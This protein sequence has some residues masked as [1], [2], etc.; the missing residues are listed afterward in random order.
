MSLYQK[1]RP[2]TLYRVKGNADVLSTLEGMLSDIENC[3]HA[4]LLHGPTGCGKTTL[5]RIIA[6]RL[7]CKGSDLKEI[8]SAQF[9]GIDTAR[10]IR[11]HSQYKAIEGERRVWIIDECH[12]MTNDAQ[13]GLLKILEDTPNHVYFVLCTTDPQKLLP[14]IRS[15]CSMFQV[16][17][18]SDEDM[19][20]LLQRIVR[21]ERQEISDE[22][23]D[24]LIRTGQGLPRT[25]IQALEQVLKANPEKREEIAKQAAFEQSQSIDLCRALMK[26]A[27]WKEIGTILNGLKDQEAEGIRR[28]V[29]GYCQAV[30][31]KGD[32]IL[33]GRIMEEFINPFYD[34]G[35]P[36][37]VFACYSITKDK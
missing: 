24:I 34:S 13:N 15:R 10:D 17:P 30:L 18:L 7:G 27:S 33:A 31:L 8:D 21:K 22:V 11:S 14:T 16:K 2:P 19:R 28:V 29:L 32:V 9:R 36:Q 5:A 1:Y 23:Y 26:R 20:S 25:T 12:K 3:T 4:F 6:D 35:F 37:L